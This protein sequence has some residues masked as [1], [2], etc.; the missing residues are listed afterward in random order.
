MRPISQPIRSV[1]DVKKIPVVRPPSALLAVCTDDGVCLEWNP[2]LEEGLAR[3]IVYVADSCGEYRRIIDECVEDTYFIDMDAQLS[4]EY[5]YVVTAVNQDGIES[6]F[7]N[8]ARIRYVRDNPPS[9]ETGETILRIP[10]R[11]PILVADACAI[12]FGGGEILVFDRRFMRMRAWIDAEGT[13]LMSPDIYGNALDITEMD[14]WG[15]PDP[16]PSTESYPATPPCYTL[17]L[18]QMYDPGTHDSGPPRLLEFK[19]VAGG[20]AIHYTVPMRK[21]ANKNFTRLFVWETW[22]ETKKN[23]GP[24][25]YLGFSRKIE[26]KLPS[27]YN[28]GYSVCL[29]DAFG[30]NGSCDGAVSYE[31]AWNTPYL[32][33][34]YWKRHTLPKRNKAIANERETSRYHPEERAMQTHPFQILNFPQGTFLLS[35]RR[36]YHTV[37]TCLSNYAQH[38]KDGIF[39][40]YMIDCAE[41]G[42]RYTVEELEY[43]YAA[44]PALE[45]PQL[46]MDASFHYRRRIARLYQL[47]ETISGF[48]QGWDWPYQE[49]GPEDA[50]N[51]GM[52][53]IGHAH[54]FWFSA[55]YAVEPEILSDNEHPVNRR[56]KAYVDSFK[57][58]G[59]AVSFWVRPEF[60]KTAPA[61]AFSDRF[62][63]LY[64]G[65]NSQTEP[66]LMDK[67]EREGLPAIKGHPEWIRYGKDGRLAAD[68]DRTAYSW[69]PARLSS[70]WYEKIII[71]TLE[72]MADLGFSAV[73]QDGGAGAMV[74]VEYGEGGALCT[75][76]YYWRWF[77]DI[78][79]LGMEVNGELPLAWGSSTLPTPGELDA[80]DP[81]A[82][83]HQI[84]RGNLD[85]SRNDMSSGGRWFSPRF[86][87]IVHSMYAGVYM[88]IASSKE[89]ADAARFCQ[90][91]IAENG[92]PDR[93]K[94]EGLRWGFVDPTGG[95]ALRGWIWDKVIWEYESGRSVEYPS[96]AAFLG[97]SGLL[98]DDPGPKSFGA[99]KALPAG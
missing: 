72:R 28:E 10:G 62:T 86:Q 78:S 30:V 57:E 15:M 23:V 32:E 29:N 20:V 84:M 56:I 92:H 75:M 93:V 33:T 53:M 94:L 73:F 39:P 97:E 48:A 77:Q 51:V 68:V 70:G 80:M 76:P 49:Y 87:H 2:G 18:S 34:V 89:H 54:H 50:E 99:P 81:W 17:P 46:Y 45:P 47:P 25:N 88:N 41:R 14:N 83:T 8:E 90:K 19:P 60:I 35:A 74:G 24:V 96:Y 59:V 16:L 26:V 43:L 79:R 82:V 21:G 67:I 13:H 12:R 66:P 61:N 91:F 5:I 55:P 1:S 11:A 31:T 95:S 27:S 64:Y 38:L 58:R 42:V 22:R 69:I 9:I 7:S 52:D 6:P 44:K 40:N 71:P 63:T 3:Y 98:K 37:F 85:G 65:Y 4:T 36:C